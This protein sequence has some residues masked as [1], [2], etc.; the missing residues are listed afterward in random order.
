MVGRLRARGPGG[1]DQR[2]AAAVA[3]D[4]VRLG[5]QTSTTVKET[6][7][8][9]QDGENEY[10]LKNNKVWAVFEKYGA[11]CT[12][13]FVYDPITQQPI[14]V[15]GAPAG[16]VSGP[17]MLKIVRTPSSLRTAATFFIAG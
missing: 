9:D 1:A 4:Q 17:R 10:I 16:L 8:V 5:T 3:S 6:A 13:A 14:N 2:F 11:R 12:Y 15:I 7:D